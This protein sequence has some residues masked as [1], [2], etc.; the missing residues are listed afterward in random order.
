MAIGSV[1]DKATIIFIGLKCN[2]I[3]SL[4]SILRRKL[5]KCSFVYPSSE[6]MG[7]L[8]SQIPSPPAYN[9]GAEYNLNVTMSV[10]FTQHMLYMSTEMYIPFLI[11]NHNPNLTR[12]S[13]IPGFN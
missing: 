11:S 13:A 8:C 1:Y 12:C 6:E 3:L 5:W 10:D 7:L 4:A 9:E 2:V